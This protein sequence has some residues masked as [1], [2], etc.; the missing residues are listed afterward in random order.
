ML[1]RDLTIEPIN[2]NTFEPIANVTNWHEGS[3]APERLCVASELGWPAIAGE[4]GAIDSL[5]GFSIESTK[6]ENDRGV[7]LPPKDLDEVR[8]RWGHATIGLFNTDFTAK[9]LAS[10]T[11]NTPEALQPNSNRD[12]EIS[13]RSITVGPNTEIYLRAESDTWVGRKRR[14]A[15]HGTLLALSAT[16]DTI[17]RSDM[18]TERAVR[19]MEKDYGDAD[20]IAMSAPP[21]WQDQQRKAGISH[22]VPPTIILARGGSFAELN[23]MTNIGSHPV[24]PQWRTPS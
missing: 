11:A 21:V 22:V 14:L 16:V 3:G 12:T 20:L 7:L 2:G 15:R 8:K 13:V 18:G 10:T 19:Y 5:V 17:T 1:V 4:D 23:P 9:G 6:H 24:P